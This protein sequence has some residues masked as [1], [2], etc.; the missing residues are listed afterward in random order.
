MDETLSEPWTFH[1]PYTRTPGRVVG[2][3]LAGLKQQ[4]VRG[5]RMADGGVLVPP[6]EH[7]P[8]TS[9]TLTEWVD[10][11]TEGAVTSWTAAGKQL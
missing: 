10:V 8:R 7:D 4:Q 2:H 6:H 3:F 11:G 5:L 1:F 9:E